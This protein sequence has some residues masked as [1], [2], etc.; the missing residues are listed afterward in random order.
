MCAAETTGMRME[1]GVGKWFNSG[2]QALPENKYWVGQKLRSGSSIT[3]YR[4]TQKDSL[5]NPY[6]GLIIQE[7]GV[8]KKVT[9]SVLYREIQR[10][11]LRL[12]QGQPDAAQRLEKE[13]KLAMWFWITDIK[14]Q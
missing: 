2:G 1:M 7:V 12:L 4:K 14:T 9:E 8:G 13:P 5:A 11:N 3:S 10:T 6:K